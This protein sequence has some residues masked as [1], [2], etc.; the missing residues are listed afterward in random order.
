MLSAYMSMNDNTSV[1]LKR[2][3][4]AEDHIE[5]QKAVQMVLQE[6]NVKV[7]I[8]HDGEEAIDM[9]L[10]NNYDIIFMDCMMPDI[11][12]YKATQTIREQEGNKH[13][14]I[15]AMTANI[16]QSGKDK[17]LEVGVD[18]YISKPVSISQLHDVVTKYL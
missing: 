10:S 2:I 1:T 13:N 18:A 5:S 7:D 12:G 8:A 3:L 16:F 11:D 6:Y 14:I 9:A 15:I 4:V 17:W